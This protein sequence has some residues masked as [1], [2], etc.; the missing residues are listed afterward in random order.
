MQKQ[1]GTGDG[2][3]KSVRPPSNSSDSKRQP[4]ANDSHCC[5]LTNT[6]PKKFRN[7][8]VKKK[9]TDIFKRE[10]KYDYICIH[11]IEYITA[12]LLSIFTMTVHCVA[13][14]N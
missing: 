9:K 6:H 14:H 1:N 10:Y 8:P 13:L 7:Q 4:E 11:H 5:C 2:K 12:V 3:T